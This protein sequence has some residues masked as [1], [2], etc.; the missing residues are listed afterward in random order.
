[1]AETE[2]EQVR[3]LAARLAEVERTLRSTIAEI[4][5]TTLSH[6]NHNPKR[7]AAAERSLNNVDIEGLTELQHVLRKL[8]LT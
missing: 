8:R 5:R 1:M 4:E 6:M 7:L 2:S 3:K